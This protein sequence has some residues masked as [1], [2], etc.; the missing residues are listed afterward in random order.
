MFR[1]FFFHL[2][3]DVKIHKTAEIKIFAN[4]VLELTVI[5]LRS[6]FCRRKMCDLDVIALNDQ[7]AHTS[8]ELWVKNDIQYW[9]K[10]RVD[11]RKEC[12]EAVHFHRILIRVVRD[13][14]DSIWQPR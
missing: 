8:A 4:F 13:N 6:N 12:G 1:S 14:D 11:M 5:H 3:Y 7:I 10:G 2:Y 9:I